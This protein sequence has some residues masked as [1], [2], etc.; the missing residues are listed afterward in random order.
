M[1]QTGA[2]TMSYRARLFTATALSILPVLAQAE[3]TFTPIDP[4][5]TDAQKRDIIVSPK[6]VVNGTEVALSYTTLARSGDV[7]NGV[8]FSQLTDQ[9]GNPVQ[10]ESEYGSVDADFTSLLPRGD[11]LFSITHFESRPAAMYI[12]EVA[13]AAD[14]TLS[15]SATRPID[16]SDVGGLWVPCAGSVTPWGSHLGSEEY[17]PD[18]R[19]HFAATQ[20]EE[21][22]EY[23]RPMA[24][25][26]GV[27]PAT[28][29][30]E[31]FRAVF[32]PYRY[33]FPVEIAVD[34]AGTTTPAKHY[35]MGRVA[36]ELALVMPDQKTAYISDDGTNVGLF[37]FVADVAGDLTAG[38]LFAA[39]WVQTSDDGAGAA[40]IEWIDLGHA[41]DATV[42]AAIVAGTRFEALF[43]VADIT[44]DGTCP[45][46]FA[47]SNAEGRAECLAVKPGME[48]IASRLETRR[49]ASMLGATTE[50]RKMEG[51]VHDPDKNVL[52]VAMSEV[53]KAMTDGDELDLGGRNDI[54]LAKNSCGAVYQLPLDDAFVAGSMSSVVEGRA[55]NYAE[56]TEFAG[57][58]C[59]IDGIANPD[60]ITFIPGL[61]TLVIGEDTGAGHQ[62]DVAWAMD[63]ASGGLTRIMSSPYGSEITSLDWY[64]N[65]NGHAYL[66]AVVQHPYGESD[67]DKAASP[68]DTRA[69]VGYIGPFPPTE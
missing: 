21:I 25:Y 5:T 3:I 24:A 23:N 50:F 39:K 57:N 31:D 52:Y 14:G 66:M 19:A 8:T 47:S 36:V 62:N 30:L 37:R 56:G 61:N 7:I 64:P 17:P 44:S 1:K 35:S 49:Y 43:D 16:F 4:A 41:D 40:N 12:S 15:Y 38:Q 45:E 10:G 67:E 6:A 33:G 32:N 42:G 2:M 58:E 20:L 18:A 68:A 11:R 51:L 53:A 29:T 28:M 34:D 22:E 26:F 54:R 65:V 63:L 13:T 55:G 69:Y 46:G 48:A 59:D 60:N 27:D 9:A